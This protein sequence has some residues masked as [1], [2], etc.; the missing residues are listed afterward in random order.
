MILLEK[1]MCITMFKKEWIMKNKHSLSPAHS[2]APLDL[3]A[4]VEAFVAQGGVIAVIPDP[5]TTN[6]PP[7]PVDEPATTEAETL[8]KLEQLKALVAKGA[9]VS[10]LQYSL[11]MN[12]R[13]IRQLAQQHGIKIN[14]SRP[15]RVQRP[16]NMPPDRD[17]DDIVAGH[18]MHYSS[19]GYSV[20][21]I[22]QFLGL[23]V[24]QV[25]DLG[26]AY[27]FEFS[28]PPQGDKA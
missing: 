11:R 8:A 25:L 20:P 18:A 17:I 28:A 1:A 21:E 27:R 4:A 2:P 19:L 5:E 15:V 9:G 13:D 12:R 16:A 10:S 3:S 14:F 22:A 24:R 7:A 26:K 23:S 6:A